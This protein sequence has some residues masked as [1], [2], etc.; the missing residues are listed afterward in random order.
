MRCWFKR[1]GGSSQGVCKW[2]KSFRDGKETE[3]AEERSGRPSTSKTTDMIEQ[4]R[5]M[6][7]RERQLTLRLTAEELSIGK[8]IVRTIVCEN[9]WKRKIRSRFVPH[10]LTEEQKEKRMQCAIDFISVSPRLLFSS[11]HRHGAWN[12]VLSARPR[13]QAP[14]DGLLFTVFATT[15]S[16]FQKSKVK[17]M[18]IAFL[19]MA[20]IPL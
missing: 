3:E 6:L 13:N 17:R 15:V 8:E 11:Y 5:E 9:L 18:L 1:T 2:F 16:R 14:I 7:A 19:D 4:V 12:L 20:G 10:R